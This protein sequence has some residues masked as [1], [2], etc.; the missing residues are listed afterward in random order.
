MDGKSFS[1]ALRGMLIIGIVGG[2]LLAGAVAGILW[3][4]L[5]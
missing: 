1:D 5:E 2:V 4:V 3:L